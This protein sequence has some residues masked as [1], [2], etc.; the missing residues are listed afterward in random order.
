MKS[1]FSKKLINAPYL[2]WSIIFIVVPLI[3][4]AYYTFTDANGSFTADNITDLVRFKEEFLISLSSRLS[5]RIRLLT[6]C[7]ALR[8]PRSE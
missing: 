5:L 1:S 6:V 7:R 4:V 3:V 8:C 2:V